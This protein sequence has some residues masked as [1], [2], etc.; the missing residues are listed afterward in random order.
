MMWEILFLAINKRVLLNSGALI[1]LLG[2][3]SA[4]TLP[5]NI[6]FSIKKAKILFV[7]VL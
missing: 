2:T 4:T 3:I 5:N 6:A 7:S 1:K